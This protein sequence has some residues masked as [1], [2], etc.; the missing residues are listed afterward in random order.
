[1]YQCLGLGSVEDG[2]C[3]EDWWHP[4]CLVGLKPDWNS[5]IGNEK[6]HKGT[7]NSIDTEK[8]ERVA[9]PANTGIDGNDADDTREQGDEA[10]EEEP[11]PPGFPAEDDFET[12][13]CYKC[14]EAHPWI[15]RYAGTAGF[16]PPVFKD[17]PK[18]VPVP[19]AN[20]NPP[21]TTVEDASQEGSSKKRK[22][23]DS[24]AQS[25][26]KKPKARSRN[27]NE[28]CQGRRFFRT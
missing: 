6:E 15:K 11:N 1:M 23:D 14:V 10:D 21:S 27:A 17:Q 4:A 22:A 16:M 18:D 3:G 9:V 26:A 24:P 5:K 19:A 2:G 8:K 25:P 20:G 28:L 12:F 13:L 7:D